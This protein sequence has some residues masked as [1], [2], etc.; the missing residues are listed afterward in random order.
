MILVF[1]DTHLAKRFKPAKFEALERIISQADQVIINGDFWDGDTTSFDNFINSKWQQ[2]FPLL[3]SKQ[4]H[5]LFG[6]HDSANK[7]DKRIYQFAD[8]AS[9]N[10]T[11]TINGQKFFFSH[12]HLLEPGFATN[13][14]LSKYRWARALA[15]FLVAQI[16]RIGIKLFG[17]PF[18]NIFF[19]RKKETRRVLDLVEKD[20]DIIYISGHTHLPFIN[21]WHNYVNSGFID[22]GLAHY[23]LIDE[24]GEIELCKE[25]Y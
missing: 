10:L 22:Y 5:Y 13:S 2:L 6:N 1:S 24:Q 20:P 9:E 18:S 4:T 15:R 12:G 7:S 3:K 21:P 8:R 17:A 14:P 11:K 19:Y 16:E 23:L 25:V